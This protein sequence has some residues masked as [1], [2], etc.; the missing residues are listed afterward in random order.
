[1]NSEGKVICWV[2]YDPA[3]GE[4]VMQCNSRKEARELAGKDGKIGVVRASH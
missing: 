2:I 3:S 1:M 4:I